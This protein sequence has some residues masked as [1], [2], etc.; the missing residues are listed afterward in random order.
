MS[1]LRSSPVKL[2][3]QDCEIT[4]FPYMCMCVYN[5]SSAGDFF[6]GDL[7]PL[8]S[9]ERTAFGK[10]AFISRGEQLAG[11]RE[12]RR[13]GLLLGQHSRAAV[14]GREAGSAGQNPEASKKML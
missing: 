13:K 12:L 8:H 5:A 4:Q 3:C 2:S 9:A 11:Q 10:A 1:L 6:S 7:H 14:Q